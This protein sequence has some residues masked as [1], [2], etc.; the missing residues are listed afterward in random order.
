MSSGSEKLDQLH[1]HHL[2]APLKPFFP[3]QN[4]EDKRIRT[5]AREFHD[6]LKEAID[7]EHQHLLNADQSI[8]NDEIVKMTL[9]ETKAEI[10]ELIYELKR[11]Q[12]EEEQL[13]MHFIGQ[14]KQLDNNDKTTPKRLKDY[15]EGFYYEV[16]IRSNDKKKLYEK[17]LLREEQ[18]QKHLSQLEININKIEKNYESI[19]KWHEIRSLR[20]TGRFKNST[21]KIQ[22]IQIPNNVS[23]QALSQDFLTKNVNIQQQ[24]QSVLHEDVMTKPNAITS[25]YN[26]E[27][28]PIQYKE[29]QSDLK[30][31]EIDETS[32]YDWIVDID[33]IT[34]IAKNG[35]KVYLSKKFADA[36]VKQESE[37]PNYGFT[38]QQHK[39][40]WEGAAVAVVGL[41]DKGKTFVLNNLTSSNLPS[42]KKVTTKGVSFKHVNVDSGT[43]LILVDTAGSYSPVKITNEL[44]IVEKEA[45]EMFITDLVF[46]ISDYFICVVNDF[47]SLDQRYLD[48]LSRNLQNSPNKTFR[49]IIVIHNLKEVESPEIL[50]HV[51][52]T[53]V[54]QIYQNGSIQRT[55]VAS[56][57]PINHQLQEKHVLWFKTEFTRHVC[58]VNDDSYLGMSINPWVFSLLR[59]WL[60]AVFV[61]VN[62][63]FSVVDSIIQF[64]KTKLSSYFRTILTLQIQDTDDF[65]VKTI[66]TQQEVQ[67]SNVRI[68]QVSIDSSGLI[69]TRPDSFLPNTDII[70]TDQ[71]I[72]YMDVPGLTKN[73]ILVYRQNVV[74]IIK[75][76]RKRPY[77]SE[78]LE[79]SERKYGE[80]AL[81]FKIPEIY[82]R[83]WS[84]F[85]VE[86]GVLTIVYE[87][88]KDDQIVRQKKQE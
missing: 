81:S 7:E 2:M 52:S 86:N 50:E 61:P 5:A 4:L 15:F 53:Q 75:G 56:I 26:L 88:D 37:I 11:I 20:Q 34:T 10:K 85:T 43:Q 42:G 36:Q 25:G 48:R 78:K 62:R 24:E 9:P 39:A 66:V 60:K 87:K 21:T 3:N 83:K 45:T 1:Q 46:E 28:K 54:T 84:T 68:P 77:D 70:A 59:Y 63:Q 16:M 69:M 30:E 71:Y 41:Y 58:L 35:W 67:D 32:V 79:R 12:N 8:I 27:Y 55:K 13:L 17:V 51:W 49:E 6:F 72:I 38:K 19:K 29:I 47:T 73:E 74:T 76:I 80:F 40:Q 22:K 18:L 33:L 44:S 31:I 57:N 14:A 82:E 64:S 23:V 65:L